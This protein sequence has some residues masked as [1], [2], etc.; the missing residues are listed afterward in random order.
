VIKRPNAFRRCDPHHPEAGEIVM[1]IRPL[2]LQMTVCVAL[3]TIVPATPAQDDVADVPSQDL[4]IGDDQ[5]K[6]YFL[7][8][9][10]EGAAEP[11]AGFGLVVVLPGGSG[12]AEFHPFVKRI[13]KHA[14]PDGY[15]IAQ[16][17]A[18]QWNS[19]QQI[20]WPTAK[21][22]ERGMQFTTEAFIDEVI[23]D[24][25]GQSKLD[26][27]R[28]FTL[29]WSSSGPAAYAASLTSD[30]IR[31]SFVAMSVFNPKFLPPLDKAKGQRYFLYHSPQDQVCPYWMAQQAAR[32]LPEHGAEAK[33]VEYAGGHG[34]RGGLYESIRGGIEWLAEQP[35]ETH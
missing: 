12:D 28:T 32:K 24:V 35:Q 29:S 5:N 31:G 20:V 19:K 1:T 7:I 10:A 18:V 15:L 25:G 22:R 34:W 30:K 8:G 26:P 6:R 17:V 27:Q 11:E 16:P 13:F 2:V 4:R 33:L 14:L 21:N 9:P 3:L 23:A